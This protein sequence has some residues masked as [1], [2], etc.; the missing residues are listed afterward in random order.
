AAYG[1]SLSNL[2]P[3]D[4]VE[5][6]GSLKQYNNLL[7]ID[8]V[9]NV[10]V[11]AS[12]VPLP[13]PV[14]F[15][16][17]NATAAYAEQ[18][19]G[20]LVRINGNT[21]IRTTS[22]G[23]VTTFAGNTNYR[24]NGSTTQEFRVNSASTGA[25]GIVNKPAPNG[26]FDIIG[27]MSQFSFSS[28]TT[29]Y[30][31]LPR[32]W[33]DFVLGAAPNINSA[34]K[35]TNI[36][37]T[38]F[39]LNFTT[40]NA[41]DTKVE[42]GTTTALGSQVT[43]TTSTTQHSIALT[44]LAPATLYYVKVTSTNSN[45]SSSSTVVPM[46]T[47]S[48]S[49][50]DI[51][52]YFNRPV[53]TTYALPNNNAVY[54]NQTIDDTLIAYI[55]RA[56]YTLDIAIYN[57]NNSGISDITAAV[58]NAH[59]RG[60][61]VRIIYEGG[62]TNYGLN[63]LNQSILKVARNTTRNIMHNKFVI[64]DAN[65][66][67][68]NDPYVWTGSTNWGNAQIN[69]DANSV[70]IMQDQSVAKTYLMEFNEM[71]NNGGS[72][73]VFGSAKTDNTPHFFNLNGTPVEVYFSPS[74]QVNTKL[75]E[76]INTADNDLHFATMLITRSDIAAAIKD[77]VQAM[78]ISNC[79]EGL[80]DDTIGASSQF[81]L[82]QQALGN[83]LQKYN[84][85]HIMHHKYILVDALAP[86][87]NPTVFAG[88]HNWSN[89]AETENDENTVIIRSLEI[90][91]QYYQEFVQRIQDQNANITMCATVTGLAKDLTAQVQPVVVY[92]NPNSGSFNVTVTDPALE[93][94]SVT[95]YDVTGKAV[96]TKS[97]K[98]GATEVS[99][100]A[101]NLPRGM[102]NLQINNGKETQYSKVL[103]Y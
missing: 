75:I 7:E 64:I 70:I 40:Q 2:N 98:V 61:T 78:N 97:Y 48:N 100:D 101:A 33:S 74:D 65:S 6:T 99:V 37:T 19:E 57:W 3:G 5:I 16:A 102:Y 51:K 79:S 60:V 62:N 18:Y 76:T 12:N 32:V 10:T 94:V 89:S 47:A 68:P 81:F 85:T 17:T 80:M 91:N 22:G 86:N 39:T 95:L 41:G 20:M 45:G 35:P 8:P 71:W 46:M 96:Y 58:N 82:I 4:S 24:L 72:S 9:T 26:T 67:N 63:S 31:L 42:Y 14:S 93:V 23:T 36:T 44:G 27:I 56:K 13:A 55:N 77:R 87:S 59:S 69:N 43:S 21:Q 1:S 53:N 34:V 92:P 84:R 83:R 103:I 54:L 52:V 88:S 15:N 29:G 73:G 38:G 11:L 66:A 28:P 25:T 49:T 30:Q 90:A 50:G